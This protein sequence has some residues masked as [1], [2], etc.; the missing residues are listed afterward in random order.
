[1]R[2]KVKKMK[3]FPLSLSRNQVGIM[4]LKKIAAFEFF[5][6]FIFLVFH[7]DY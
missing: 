5:Y 7:A 2:V 3:S 1:M 4:I 6:S